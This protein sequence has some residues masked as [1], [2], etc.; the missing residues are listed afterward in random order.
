MN[1]LN[2]LQDLYN[3]TLDEFFEELYSHWD[4][5]PEKIVSKFVNYFPKTISIIVSRGG[6]LSPFKKNVLSNLTSEIDS[7]KKRR[8]KRKRRKI[9]CNL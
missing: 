5:V 6:D 7:L 1:K 4:T 9:I 2:E 8:K 3:E